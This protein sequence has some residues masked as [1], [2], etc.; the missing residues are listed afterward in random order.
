MVCVV[1]DVYLLVYAVYGENHLISASFLKMLM[2]MTDFHG[3]VC[4][5]SNN[6]SVLILRFME[7]GVLYANSVYCFWFKAYFL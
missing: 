5:F 7:A 4:Y 3:H 1:C 6:M 2:P